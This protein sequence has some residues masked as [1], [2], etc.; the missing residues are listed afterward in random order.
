MYLA[1]INQKKTG[2]ALL[3]PYK[4]DFRDTIT[5]DK[6]EHGIMIKNKIYQEDTVTPNVFTKE[7]SFRYMKQG[8][9]A[10][11]HQVK[12]LGQVSMKICVQSLAPLSGLKIQCCHELD[13][14][15]LGSCV[16]VAVV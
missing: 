6:E 4:V 8:V 9:P 14:M 1:N 16:A 11:V 15:Q 2:V 5:K 12:S 13:Q 10:V 7:Q 3:I